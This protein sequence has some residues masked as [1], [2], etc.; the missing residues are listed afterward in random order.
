[1]EILVKLKPIN[2][3][4]SELDSNLLT[5]AILY[6]YNLLYDGTEF[7]NLL[8]SKK[9]FISNAFFFKND[10]Y[11]LPKPNLKYKIK[12]TK[13]NKEFKKIN[14]ISA[15]LFNKIISKTETE[16][17]NDAFLVEEIINS[18]KEIPKIISSE[19]T[20]NSINRITGSSFEGKLFFNNYARLYS[21]DIENSN[22]GFYF[23]IKLLDKNYEKKIKASINLMAERGI[24]RDKSTGFGYYK[25]E[26]ENKFPIIQPENGER[27]CLL[28]LYIPKEEELNKIKLEKSYY[29]LV[30]KISKL[31]NGYVRRTQ[32][33]FKEGSIFNSYFENPGTII[34]YNVNGYYVLENGLG[35]SIRIR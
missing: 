9:I 14:F 6:N 34:K 17:E 29:K 18:K 30:E 12:D 33:F 35:F 26:F 8:E 23:L 24:G 31:P 10:K 20:H 25:V 16:L 1:M 27:M 2:K 15:E 28:S 32:A 13:I 5:G 21:E 7:V 3:T 4:L 19:E 22:I 11:F